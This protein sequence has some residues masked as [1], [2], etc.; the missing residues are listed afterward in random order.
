MLFLVI[1]WPP[2]FHGGRSFCGE[3][4]ILP[5][6]HGPTEPVPPKIH[7]GMGS[8]RPKNPHG[9]RST[10]DEDASLSNNHGP[11]EPV[12]PKINGGM[13]SARPKNDH[14]VR[15][16][17]GENHGL[18]EPVP[19][20][21]QPRRDRLRQSEDFCFLSAIH[22]CLKNLF[23]KKFS[24][25]FLPP[26]TFCLTLVRFSNIQCLKSSLTRIYSCNAQSGPA[27]I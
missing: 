13:G 26:S 21:Q 7:G 9:V 22:A 8:A 27:N 11:T 14:G 17:C 18:T 6:N 5:N 16:T 19:P 2:V 12:P 3:D 4:T 25:S 15:A 20:A 1:V 23:L 24:K 10:C